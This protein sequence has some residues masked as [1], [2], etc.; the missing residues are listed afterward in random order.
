MFNTMEILRQHCF[1]DDPVY[2]EILNDQS[3]VFQCTMGSVNYANPHQ[4]IGLPIFAIHGNHDDPSR[5]SSSGEAL[6][7][8]DLLA[9]ANLIN[10]IGK[11]SRVDEIEVLPILIAKG[12]TKIALYGLGAMRD[13]RLNRMWNQKKVKFIRLTPEQGRDEFFNIFLLHQN[14][15]YGRGRK[16]CI[17]ESMIP[18]WIG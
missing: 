16:S 15:D 10:Y 13:E 2:L 1:S 12:K 6:A 14:R 5:D 3:E 17:H 4:S 7:A 8:L 11:S 9:V 18:E